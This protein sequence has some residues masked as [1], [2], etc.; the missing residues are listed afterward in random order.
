MLK[1]PA[2]LDNEIIEAVG[3]DFEHLTVWVENCHQHR[4]ASER[5]ETLAAA[6]R[7]I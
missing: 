5:R 6:G 4:D 3:C 7:P 2:P 1:R